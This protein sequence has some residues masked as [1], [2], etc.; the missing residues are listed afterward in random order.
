MKK[1]FNIYQ[2]NVFIQNGCTVDGCGL[3]NKYK[4]YVS[5]VED[6]KFKEMMQRWMAKEF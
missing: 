5:F 4:T 6:K 2:A 1:I 3:G